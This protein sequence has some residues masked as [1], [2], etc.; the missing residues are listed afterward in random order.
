VSYRKGVLALDGALGI[1]VFDGG[2]IVHKLRVL[3]PFSKRRRFVA[4]V[5]ARN[6][7]LGMLTRTFAFGS[8]EGR[9]DADLHDLETEGLKPLQFDA[10]IRSSPGEYPRVVSVGALRDIESLGE[11]GDP[12]RGL[13]SLPA[14]TF[15][16]FGYSRIDIGCRLKDGVCLLDGIAREDGGIVLM[17]GSGIPS[18]RII[19][20]NSRIDWEALVA[21]I[22]EKIAG[23]PGVVIE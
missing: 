14:R 22:R 11:E 20:Y 5:T 2:L 21:R 13:A 10:R 8:I 7:D 18:V 9:F 3:N 1:E 12:A 19:G 16:G 23:K 17:E 6:L 4:D 15:G